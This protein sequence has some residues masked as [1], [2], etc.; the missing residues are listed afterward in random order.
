MTIDLDFTVTT[1]SRN[2]G[3]VAIRDRDKYAV[4][5]VGGGSENVE[6]LR[7]TKSPCVVGKLGD[8][9]QLAGSEAEYTLHQLSRV[10][11]YNSLEIA[12]ANRAPNPVVKADFQVRRAGVRVPCPESREQYFTPISPVVFVRVLQQEHVRRLGYNEAATR[13]R[14]AGGNAEPFCENGDG[15]CAAVCIRIVKDFYRVTPV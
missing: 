2:A 9:F 1:Q 6:C 5:I 8:L 12:V 11:A 10:S 7:K 14:E 13:E 15:V 3:I 4:L